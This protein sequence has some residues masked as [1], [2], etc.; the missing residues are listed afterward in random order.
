MHGL[1]RDLGSALRQLRMAPGLSAAV[2]LALGLGIG[3]N[4]ALFGIVEALELR[5]LP[6]GDPERLVAV[7]LRPRMRTDQ[8]PGPLSVPDAEELARSAPHLASL[9]VWRRET[10]GWTRRGETRKVNVL[11][12]GAGLFRTLG[13]PLQ[14]GRELQPAEVGPSPTHVAVVSDRFW[15]NELGGRRRSWA[16]RSTST[17]THT[18]SSESRPRARSSRSR[19]RRPTSSFRSG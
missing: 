5:P 17:A 15:R 11:L 10:F 16:P 9:V 3:A 13:L 2:I 19:R 8:L 1:A 4:A 18:R 7:G 12:A 6:L 14:R